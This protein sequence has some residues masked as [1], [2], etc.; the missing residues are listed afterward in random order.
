[1]PARV[2]ILERIVVNV[3]IPVPGLDALGLQGDDGIR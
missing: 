2:R 1:M 3:G